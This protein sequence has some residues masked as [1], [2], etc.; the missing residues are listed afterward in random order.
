MTEG[1]GAPAASVPSGTPDEAASGP[2]AAPFT[3]PSAAPR[4]PGPPGEVE[5]HV[6]VDGRR[7]ESTLLALR[8]AI[9]EVPLSLEAP[10]VDEAR[11]ERRKLLGQ[12]DD[13][14]LPR[15]RQSGAPKSG[16]PTITIVRSSWS[17]S[18]ARNDPSTMELAFCPP[19]PPA[20]WQEEQNC[21]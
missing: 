20:P 18:S 15:L 1:P 13:Y 14:L 8:H 10:Q 19:R 7:L 21:A 12:I 11:A 17:L 5:P 9:V 6:R 4:A 2:R 3:D 16:R